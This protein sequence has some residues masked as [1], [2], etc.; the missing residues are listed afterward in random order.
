M[1]SSFRYTLTKL[2][3]LPSSLKICLRRSGY[4]A[5][6]AFS[7]SPT[8]APATATASWRPVNCRRGVGIKTLGISVNQLLLD[9]FGLLGVGQPAIGVVEFALLNGEHHEGIPG[10]RI[11]QIGFGKIGVAIGVRVVD[12]DQVHVA[13]V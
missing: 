1:S 6:S 9:G 10:A 4:W 13:L 2:R 5:V 11:L 12:T 3:T 7:T 8:V